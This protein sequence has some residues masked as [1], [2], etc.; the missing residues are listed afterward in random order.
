[1]KTTFKEYLTKKGLGTSTIDTYNRFI[2]KAFKLWLYVN[3]LDIQSFENEHLM[4]YI[5]YRKT[6]NIKAGT[7]NAEIKIISHYLNFK[8]LTNICEEIRVRGA[9]RRIPHD[10]FTQ[11]E[12]EGIYVKFPESRNAWTREATFKRYHI[13]L[14]LKIYQGLQEKELQ[15]LETSH[16]KLESGKIYVPGTKKSN[17]RILELKPFQILPLSEYLLK[18]RTNYLKDIEGNRLFPVARLKRG[19]P[20][21][22]KMIN[23]YEP[24]LTGLGQIRASV[25]TNWLKHYNL[26]EVQYMAGHRYVSS[27]ERYRTDNLEDLQKELEKYHPLI[28]S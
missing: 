16:L 7:I 6:Q 14:G 10:L 27:T 5:R 17:K 24:K 11:K 25:I 2:E 22:K 21:I 23:R 8:G 12:L 13:I 28:G 19:M 18:E 4:Q 15:K 20:V 9:Q 26:R 1:M 3:Q